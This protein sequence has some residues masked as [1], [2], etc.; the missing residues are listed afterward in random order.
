MYEADCVDLRSEL[1]LVAPEP[2][3]LVVMLLEVMPPVMILLELILVVV[4]CT[5]D[6]MKNLFSTPY[7][8][9]IEITIE[10]SLCL[11]NFQLGMFLCVA[12]GYSYLICRY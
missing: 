9:I 11:L 1:C 7:S 5:I 12:F 4:I 6:G 8:W 3:L 10:L 2:I